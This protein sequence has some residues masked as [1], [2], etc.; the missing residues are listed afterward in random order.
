[1]TVS[2][3][4]LV[5]AESEKALVLEVES[6]GTSERMRPQTSAIRPSCQRASP[7]SSLS[8]WNCAVRM[9]RP[10]TRAGVVLAEA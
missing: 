5:I 10:R 2:G 9:S 8:R 1:M 3:D 7:R 4:L 6:G